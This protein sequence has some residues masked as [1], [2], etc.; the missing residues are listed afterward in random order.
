MPSL[1]GPLRQ[2]L[3]LSFDM[4]IRLYLSVVLSVA[5]ALSTALSAEYSVVDLGPGVARAISNSGRVAGYDSANGFTYDAVNGRQ[6]TP[7]LTVYIPD[8]PFQPPGYGPYF[9][10]INVKWFGLND[11]GLLVGSGVMSNRFSSLRPNVDLNPYPIFWN[12]SGNP[13]NLMAPGTFGRAVNSAGVAVG[14]AFRFDGTTAQ[15]VGL[16]ATLDINDAG[17]IS[18]YIADP[19]NGATQAAFWKD[20]AVQVVTVIDTGGFGFRY[21]FAATAINSAGQ[22]AGNI[23][24]SSFGGSYVYGFLWSPSQTNLINAPTG[25]LFDNEVLVNDLND[26][27]AVVGSWKNAQGQRA[28]IYRNETVTDLNTL[29]PTGGWQLTAAYA[30]NGSGQIV[31]EGVLN[32]VTRAFLLNPLNPGEGQPPSILVQPQGGRFGLGETATLS[33]SANGTPPLTYQWQHEGTNLVGETSQTLVLSGLDAGDNGTYRVIIK[34]TAGEAFSQ[35]AIVTV[36]DP[37]I[38]VLR[39]AGVTVTGAVGGVYRIDAS[40]S[41]TLPTW[42]PLTQFTLT[43]SPQVWID[44]ES[45][46]NTGPRYYRS[47]RILP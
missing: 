18:G 21:G 38:G 3:N 27:G 37:E 39:Y 25:G 2:Y 41:L 1:L 9:S 6:A 10:L 8:D 46:T 23:S 4:K 29:I 45:G 17:T 28:Y 47:V 14:G 16:S 5:C 36:L 43:N 19:G 32:G 40:P 30:I 20:G 11:A 34:N 35:E 12:G 33:V 31:G 42:S 7:P 15:D 22:L 24:Y 26:A 44:L 13:T